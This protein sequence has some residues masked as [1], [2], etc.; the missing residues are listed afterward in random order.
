MFYLS[1]YL[2]LQEGETALHYAADIRPNNRENICADADIVKL[3]FEYNAEASCVTFLVRIFL[4]RG[5]AI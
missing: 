4:F 1:V 5:N 3:L 2:F